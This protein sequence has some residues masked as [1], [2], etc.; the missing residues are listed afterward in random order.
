MFKW[1]LQFHTD[2]IPE[3][4]DMCDTKKVS[5]K[6]TPIGLMSHLQTI[7]DGGGYLHKGISLYLQEL[8][9]DHLGG[10]GHKGLYKP[11][12]DMYKEAEAEERRES[13]R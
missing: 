10:R 9:K 11:G 13:I 2:G 3:G 12:D 1:Q 8:Y 5:K 4:I 6:M 7:A